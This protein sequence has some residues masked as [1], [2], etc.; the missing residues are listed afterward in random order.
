MSELIKWFEKRRE[1]KAL[2]T[3]QQHLALTTSI[4]E[5][6]EKAVN[7]AIRNDAKEMRACIERIAGSESEADSLRRRVMDEV[8]RGELTPTAREDIMHLVK[9]VDM[10]ADWSREST[11][12]LSVIPMEHVP[13]SIKNEFA[14]M[15]KGIK[16]C[17]LSLQKCVN[18]MMTKPEEALQAADVV[19]REEEKVDDI[20]EKARILLGTEDLPKAG[21]AVLVGQLFEAME[22]IADACEDACDYVRV[23]IVR[24]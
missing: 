7:A 20:H 12:V 19:E 13:K 4:V 8:S 5:D 24:K 21:V 14:A 17:A 1:T 15:M 16:E 23:I 3:I 11:R 2:A 6:L 10:V 9:R 22:M 18:K